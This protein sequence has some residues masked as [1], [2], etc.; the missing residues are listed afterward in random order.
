[1][2]TVS[3]FV[4]QWILNC[5]CGFPM[6]SNWGSVPMV[7]HLVCQWIENWCA[8][9]FWIVFVN[10][11]WFLTKGLSQW[12]PIWSANGIWN[13]TPMDSDL[14]LW[15]ANVFELRVCA[16]SFAF[17]LPMDSEIINRWH[18]CFLYCQWF[19]YHFPWQDNGDFHDVFNTP[20]WHCDN[21]N[22]PTLYVF[23]LEIFITLYVCSSPEDVCKPN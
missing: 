21:C 16:N 22:S 9:G 23:A 19:R 11:Q 17:D 3:H 1:M 12:F 13:N 5:I 4:C 10:C 18:L 2:P 15:I 7:S 6:F 20:Q 8:N 14:F